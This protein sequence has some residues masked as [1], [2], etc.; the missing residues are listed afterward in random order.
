MKVYTFTGHSSTSHHLGKA[1][2]FNDLYSRQFIYKIGQTLGIQEIILI[3]WLY[4]DNISDILRLLFIDII[5]YC[6]VFF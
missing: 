1:Y 5:T 4:P 2:I 3:S 6:G